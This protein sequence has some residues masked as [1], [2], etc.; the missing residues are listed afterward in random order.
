MQISPLLCRNDVIS[1]K[2]TKELAQLGKDAE[3]HKRCIRRLIRNS[4]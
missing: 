2:A 4:V 3:E 1:Y